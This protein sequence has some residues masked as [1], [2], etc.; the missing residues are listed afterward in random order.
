MRNAWRSAKACCARLRRGRHSNFDFNPFT[1]NFDSASIHDHRDILTEGRIHGAASA[2]KATVLFT[3]APNNF[4]LVIA[5]AVCRI[6]SGVGFAAIIDPLEV[7][8]MA[9]PLNVAL[10][11]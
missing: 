1:A 2:R 7:P 4:G 11:F 6:N 3:A 8:V 9:A 10:Y 5:V